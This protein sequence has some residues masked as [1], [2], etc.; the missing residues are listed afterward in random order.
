MVDLSGAIITQVSAHN[1]GNQSSDEGYFL[2]ALPIVLDDA[3]ADALLSYCHKAFS[4]CTEIYHYDHEVSLEYNTM[5][6]LSAKYLEDSALCHDVSQ[7]I[8]RHLYSQSVHPHI[9]SGDVLIIRLEQVL[10][11]DQLVDAIAILK[12]ENKDGFLK[13]TRHGDSILV[14][15]QE[16]IQLKRM[17]KGA[18][19]LDVEAAEGYRILSVDNNNYDA[20][21]WYSDFLSIAHVHDH[22]FDTKAYVEMCKSF[23][24]DVIK[25]TVDKKSQVDFI[26]QTFQYIEQVDTVD[27]AQFKETMFADEETSGAFDDYKRRYEADRGIAISDSFAVSDE[28]MKQQK[29]KLRNFIKL[30]TNIKIQLGFSNAESVDR[31]VDRGWDEDKGMYYY[32]CYFNS[33]T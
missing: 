4:K 20:S 28:V 5:Y 2:S 33:E 32:K 30:D 8:T 23:A 27:V 16:G 12:A 21:Y 1:V 25:E 18:L 29:R 9:K 26:Q 7:S 13:L 15:K 6:G 10:L 19:V 17:D 22:N 14:D 24:S 11:V 3:L 31:F